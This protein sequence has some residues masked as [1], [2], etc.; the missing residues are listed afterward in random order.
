[1]IRETSTDSETG[2]FIASHEGFLT[3]ISHSIGQTYNSKSV[4]IVESP[5]TNR[6]DVTANSYGSHRLVIHEDF[7]KNGCNRFLV[8]GIGNSNR[9]V[10]A[11]IFHYLV[12]R[13]SGFCRTINEIARNH[14]YAVV[15]IHVFQ[16][17]RHRIVY[18]VV[19]EV[20]PVFCTQYALGL[21]LVHV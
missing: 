21:V 1:M 17:D 8:V 5:V 6:R 3:N 13:I 15:N 16:R 4:T 11:R 18:V 9:C 12:F 19:G 7:C 14:V 2:E 10:T 20:V